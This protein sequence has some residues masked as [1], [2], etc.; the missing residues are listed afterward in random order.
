MG[1]KTIQIQ[2]SGQEKAALKT[3]YKMSDSHSLRHR[4]KI[5][6]LSNEHYAAKEIASILDTN[7]ISVYN[8]LKDI[9]HLA[10]GDY[11]Q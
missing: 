3:C 9:R 11:I 7:A 2:L 5:L 4:C 6:L 1:R 8:W 10:L